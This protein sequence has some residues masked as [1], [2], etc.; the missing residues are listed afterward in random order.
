MKEKYVFPENNWYIKVTKDN[1]E[2]LDNWRKTLDYNRLLDIGEYINWAGS[3][4]MWRG[5]V[6]ITTD[7]FKE[8]VL[9]ETPNIP[10][11][12]EDYSYLIGFLD[13]LQNS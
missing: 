9:K 12:K 2:I 7:Q 10:T 8:Y 5:L 1:K 13:K 6:E 11:I 4:A 3:G